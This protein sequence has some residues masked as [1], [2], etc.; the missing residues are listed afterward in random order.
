MVVKTAKD[1][2]ILSCRFAGCSAFHME[3]KGRASTAQIDRIEQKA[4]THS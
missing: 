2:D 3:A 4:L 1:N